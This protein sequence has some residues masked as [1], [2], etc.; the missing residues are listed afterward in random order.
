MPRI[1][2]DVSRYVLLIILALYTFDAYLSIRSGRSRRSRSL[3]YLRQNILMYFFLAVGYTVLFANSRSF[4]YLLEALLLFLYFAVFIIL[5]VKILPDSSRLLFNHMMMLMSVGFLIQSRLSSGY[6]IKQLILASLGLAL[7]FI[8]AIIFRSD[9]KI[10]RFTSLFAI[11]GL[12]MLVLVAVLGRREYGAKLSISLGFIS[13]QP[14]EFVKILFSLF[15]ASGLCHAEKNKNKMFS[16]SILMISFLH[17]LILIANRDLGGAGIIFVIMA[18]IYY[19]WSGNI[20]IIIGSGAALVSSLI[21]LSTVFSH[22]S[23]RITA[24]IDPLSHFETSG[25]QMSQSLFAISSGRWFGTG[26]L[27]GVPER[28]PVVSK[29]FVFSAISEEMGGLFAIILIFLCVSCFILIMNISVVTRS[30]FDRLLASGLGISY[31]FQL[32]LSIGGVI[33]FIPSTGV[34]LPFISYG[35]SSLMASFITFSIIQGMYSA[36]LERRKI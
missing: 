14:I 19:V 13:F 22:I 18:G 28:I 26:L 25:Y 3:L 4:F 29:D 35:G 20:L 17:I 8:I 31:G 33:K 9:N 1:V 32:L 27:K 21:L 2:T 15:L 23:T 6:F 16:L 10:D 30:G 24:W 34:T 36:R 12:M 11:A 7:F 5:F